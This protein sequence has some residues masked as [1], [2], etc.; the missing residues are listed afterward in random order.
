MT[1]FLFILQGSKVVFGHEFV[2]LFE[3][4][5]VREVLLDKLEYKE[6]TRTIVFFGCC[7]EL[8]ILYLFWKIGNSLL[9]K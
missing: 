9:I 3:V 4:E 6:L 7:M 1:T 5:I 8:G 2:I